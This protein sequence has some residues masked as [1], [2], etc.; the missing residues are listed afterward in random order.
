M[1]GT[2][3]WARVAI[4]ALATA[5][6][7]QELP[8][9][10]PFVALPSVNTPPSALTYAG[11]RTGQFGHQPHAI[12]RRPAAP[13]LA[14]VVVAVPS[15][16]V[17]TATAG[18]ASLAA[19]PRV[20]PEARFTAGAHLDPR[21]LR[22]LTV[23]V[24]PEL[25]RDSVSF[26][27]EPI[28]EAVILGPL[29]GRL[30]PGEQRTLVLTASVPAA[31][32]A[33]AQTVAAVHFAGSQGGTV[34]VPVQLQVLQVQTAT[35]RLVQPRFS[36]RPGDRI[37]MRYFVTNGGNVTDT[38]DLVVTPP[39]AWSLHGTPM[40][41]VLGAGETATGEVIG[42][43]PSAS[44]TGVIPVRFSVSGAR[45][46]LA[47][48][49]AIVEVLDAGA[50]ASA[51]GPTLQ[52]GVASVLGG[53]SPA[54]PVVGLEVSGPLTDGLQIRGRLVQATESAQLDQRALARV[55][56]F[57]GAPYL[58]LA[59]RRWQAT[60]GTTGRS[61]SDITGVNVYGRGAS[62]EWD[63]ARWGAAALAARPIAGSTGSSTGQLLGAQVSAHVSGGSVTAMATDLQDPQFAGRKLEALGLGG[64]TPPF[65][66][67]TVSGE[68]A[69]RR[70]ATGSGMGWSA[71]LKR[72]TL[73]EFG[74][75]RVVHAPGGSQAFARA[76][77]ELTAVGSRQ[78]GRRLA[79]SAGYWNSNDE[80]QTFSRLN[81]SGWSVA[82]RFAVTDRT[83]VELEARHSAFDAAGSSGDFGN[84]ETLVR[85]GVSTQRGP[86]YASASATIGSSGRNARLPGGL[87]IE[88][89]AGRQSARLV[90]GLVT[91]RGVLEA[92]AS[93]ERNGAGIGFLP[94]QYLL[95]LKADRFALGSSPAAPLLNAEIQRYG[96]FGDRPDVM[97]IRAGVQSQLPGDLTLTLDIEHNPLITGTSG[98]SWVPVVKVERAL[99][100]PLAMLQPRAAG[101]VFQDLNGNGVRD[102][103]EPPLVGVVVRRGDQRVLTDRSGR[104][105]FPGQSDG[106]VRVDETSLPFG[107]VS[108]PAV[109]AVP[110]RGRIEIGVLPTGVVEVV[111]VPSAD[112]AG[113]VPQVSLRDVIVSAVDSAGSRWT[114]KADSAGHATF[115]ALPPGRY[116]LE[117]DFNGLR[118]PVRLRGAAPTFELTPGRSEAP[119]AVP[120]YPRPLRLF[121]PANPNRRGARGGV[122]QGTGG[123]RP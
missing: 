10:R 69:E 121:D 9:G 91:A 29:Q 59:G 114:A 39:A 22:V 12:P 88:T 36:A 17:A 33:G 99:H 35:I 75:L 7:R 122:Q 58:T 18:V 6:C 116:H 20:E 111:L 108:N 52:A 43:V 64:I 84:D 32:H 14:A 118:E 47:R 74:Q 89:S 103:G 8:A 94:H 70:Y 95:A 83:T 19:A 101:V 86:S 65:S 31:A 71:E 44:S 81:S 60:G 13:T 100:V 1:I 53:G 107:L 115:H 27:I 102:R 117:F 93:I 5:A 76:R 11:I 37:A 54:S 106:P 73:T 50:H 113:R 119:I 68:I 3:R 67:V 4:V 72:Q 15:P 109:R 38:F 21:N 46:P 26:T 92:S 51:V 42:V 48:I 61:F 82:P 77:D 28:G 2:M 41:Y 24:P 49:D 62:F 30:G 87:P 96:W 34:Q 104:F 66:G 55:G 23:V 98:G 63:G 79:L 90:A 57:V 56:Y 78:F 16:I 110:A 120:L 123:G 85:L 40:R 112:S 25:T 80:S 105:L 97:V 45:G